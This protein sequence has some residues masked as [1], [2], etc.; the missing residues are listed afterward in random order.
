[1]IYDNL[2]P[3]T[4]W[5]ALQIT[6]DILRRA[7][8]PLNVTKK[9][10]RGH[11][12]VVEGWAKAHNPPSSRSLL[13]TPPTSP[14]TY[15]STRGIS[16][17]HFPTWTWWTNGIMDRWT[18]GPVLISNANFLTEHQCNLNT[19]DVC[20]SRQNKIAAFTLKCVHVRSY[21]ILISLRKHWCTS[22]IYNCT[23]CQEKKSYA[24]DV[25]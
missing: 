9:V 7:L 16:L 17:S 4:D 3:S 8:L 13:H 20:N 6:S 18:D 14:P 24:V 25:L 15:S 23:N 5:V 10:M 21:V 2:A 1:M 11:S 19:Q 12:I 22:V